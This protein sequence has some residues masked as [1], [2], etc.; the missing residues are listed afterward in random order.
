MQINR[1]SIVVS[2]VVFIG[3]S[4]YI[5]VSIYYSADRNNN[6]SSLLWCKNAFTE[7]QTFK[8]AVYN[9]THIQK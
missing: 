2:L 9:T 8:G 6:Y 1:W 3:T 7:A 4:V 5:T